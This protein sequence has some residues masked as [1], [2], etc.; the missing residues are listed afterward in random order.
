MR[1]MQRL[2]PGNPLEHLGAYRRLTE[3]SLMVDVQRWADS[4]DPELQRLGQAWMNIVC[5]NVDWE[6]G[7]R[8]DDQLSS[9]LG[10][11]RRR[12]IPSPTS[13]NAG[14]AAKLPQAIRGIPLKDRRRPSLSSPPAADYPRVGRISCSIRRRRARR[15]STTTSCFERC[16]S[17]SQSFGSIRKDHLHD[18]ELNR[19]LNSVL[20]DVGGCEDETCR[21]LQ[22]RT[23]IGVCSRKLE[24]RIPKSENKSKTAISNVRNGS[25]RS[26]NLFDVLDL[27]ACGQLCLRERSCTTC[28][29]REF[30]PQGCTSGFPA[31]R[32]LEFVSDFGFCSA[33]FRSNAAPGWRGPFLRREYGAGCEKTGN[34]LS[35][36]RGCVG[37]R[38]VFDSPG[39]AGRYQSP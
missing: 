25:L 16:R 19:A 13:S 11:S 17:A 34:R 8:A 38:T 15:N 26:R 32:S 35:V 10:P 30:D 33:W 7:L 24:I 3:S 39:R 5:R 9:R 37:W 21:G 14:S 28:D 12:S 1:T 23:E 4:D 22:G 27:A 6:N 36:C 2:F 20:G 31:F 18:A 29:F